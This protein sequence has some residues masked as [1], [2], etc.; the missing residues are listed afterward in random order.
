MNRI[1]ALL[2]VA[3]TPHLVS[4][5]EFH[6]SVNGDDQ[7]KGSASKPFRTISAA[8]Q[9][10]QRGDV[11]TVHA[12]VYRER[13][14]PPRGGTSDTKRIV[15]QAAP[16]EKVEIKGSEVVTNWVKVQDN[17]WKVALPNAIFG[18][19]NPYGDLIRGD[20]F[21]PRGR[22]HHTGAVYLNGDWLIEAAKL[23]EVLMPAGASPA[24]LTQGGDQYLL[25][26]AWLRPGKGAGNACRR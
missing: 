20:W 9:V 26:V 4:A 5:K 12:G 22:Q 15:Y 8:A 6:V 19:F 16:G 21:D 2:L 11:I 24:W 1:I 25:N 14:A 10:A 13:I 7:N 23:E 3:V 17:V 18:S